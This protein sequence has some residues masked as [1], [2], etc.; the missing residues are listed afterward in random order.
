MDL[1]VMAYRLRWKVIGVWV[2]CAAAVIVS[3]LRG[4]AFEWRMEIDGQ[5][6]T[7]DRIAMMAAERPGLSCEFAKIMVSGKPE[8]IRSHLYLAALSDSESEQPKDLL[9]L[10]TAATEWIAEQNRIY[11]ERQADTVAIARER[12]NAVSQD[13]AAT[14]I[15]TRAAAALAL[16]QAE[17]NLKFPPIWK[18]SDCDVQPVKSAGLR[19]WLPRMAGALAAAVTIVFVLEVWARVRA[20]AQAMPR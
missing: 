16:A 17:S 12:L 9:A 2:V 5:G 13:H 1:A 4:P 19:S 7:L 6:A 18:I 15:D 11:L 3:T 10:R 8:I 14:A 20:A